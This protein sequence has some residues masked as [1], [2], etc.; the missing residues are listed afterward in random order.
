MVATKLPNV[1]A[2]RVRRGMTR[3]DLSQA[4]GV[5]RK[6]LYLWLTTGNIPQDKLEALAD[7][8]DVKAEYLALSG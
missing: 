1:E 5:T 8:F 6:T 2:E 3:D 7:L 4:L